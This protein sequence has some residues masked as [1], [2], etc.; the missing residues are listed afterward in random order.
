M[1]RTLLFCSWVIACGTSGI[2]PVDPPAN[3]ESAK[4]PNG[5]KMKSSGSEQGYTIKTDVNLVFS[6][7]TVVGAVQSELRAEDFL[8]F[9]NNVAQQVS[10]FS[11]DQ[12]PLAVALLVDSSGSITEHLHELQLAAIMALRRLTPEDQVALYAFAW[13]FE[14]LSNLTQN[15]PSI[16]EI[17][18]KLST[19]GGTDIYGTVY[20]AA[21][22]LKQHA[23]NH[24]RAM[25]LIS[26]NCHFNGQVDIGN[27]RMELLENDIV[28]FDLVTP[29]NQTLLPFCMDSDPKIQ[30]LA[31]ETGGEVLE[32]QESTSL[33]TALETAM[34][35]FRTQYTL[36][37]SPSNPGAHGSFHKLTVRLAGQNRC[38]K[39]RILARSG[40]YAGVSKP[41]ASTG[42]SRTAPVLSWQKQ[43]QLL[44][45]RGVTIAAAAPR[46][47]DEISFKV[48]AAKQADSDN[49]PQL[50]VDLQIKAAGIDLSKNEAP[51]AGKLIVAIFYANEH[52]TLLGSS[53][54]SIENPSKE[55]SD[56]RTLKVGIP[57][58]TTIPLKSESQVLKIVVYD[59]RSDKVGSKYIQLRKADL[60]EPSH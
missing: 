12:I 27:C 16:A 44:V 7:V 41:V 59:E 43:D 5:Q 60:K 42:E 17:V 2:L 21:Q 53:W 51:R 13:S 18:G 30:R 55:G 37:F 26:D 1:V 22:Y 57:F 46:E 9:D 32:V 24:R 39:C 11:H 19:Q 45:Q 4:A 52:G 58:S 14:R 50:R 3:P 54:W 15:R 40:Y 31:E 49:K 10:Y 33:K 23:P 8:I 25:I 29:S 20:D 48:A 34:L 35:R 38:P 28:L 36:G 6:N 47:M 56:A